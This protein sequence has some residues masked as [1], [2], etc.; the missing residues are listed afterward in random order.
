M[1]A[2][3]QTDSKEHMNAFIGC[4]NIPA[5]FI[6]HTHTDQC[7]Y[8]SR[9]T[10]WINTPTPPLPHQKKK[11]KNPPKNKNNTKPQKPNPKTLGHNKLFSMH[12]GC[13]VCVSKVLQRC[14]SCSSTTFLFSFSL[15]SKRTNMPMPDIF[16]GQLKAWKYFTD[17]VKQGLKS[18]QRN[19]WENSKP[20]SMPENIQTKYLNAINHPKPMWAV[21]EFWHMPDV[22]HLC[23]HDQIHY[24]P[25]IF[26]GTSKVHYDRS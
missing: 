18:E 3:A 11:E 15:E 1:C 13:H 19:E 14:Q 4:W 26:F 5:C 17:S 2:Y 7:Y 23:Y 12:T 21:L 6:K 9:S 25:D 10:N 22:L 24:F 20:A 8:S 16:A